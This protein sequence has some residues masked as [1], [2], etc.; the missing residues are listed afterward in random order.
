M[1]KKRNRIKKQERIN[2]NNSITH[3]MMSFRNFKNI[4]KNRFKINIF[5]KLKKCKNLKLNFKNRN[6]SKIIKLQTYNKLLII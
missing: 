3:F 4:N 1:K 6:T 5:N 2:Y